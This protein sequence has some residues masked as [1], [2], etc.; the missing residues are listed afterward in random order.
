[1]KDAVHNPTPLQTG[2]TLGI[3]APAGG[4]RDAAAFQTGISI[5]Q[6]MGF[7]VK[8]PK[9]CWENEISGYLAGDAAERADE[10][11]R[12][13]ADSEVKGIIALRGGF[14]CLQI[15]DRLDFNLI[16]E[17]P[18]ILIGFSDLTIILNTIF[19]QTKLP[20]FH[21]PTVTTLA[22]AAP[23]AL[24][25]FYKCLTTNIF[26]YPALHFPFLEI[27]HNGLT[28]TAEI[29]GGNLTTLTTLLGT[30]WDFSYS[31][32]ILLLEDVGEPI[33][34]IDRM[35]T[36]LRLAGKFNQLAAI[37][38]G[39]FHTAAKQPKLDPLSHLRYLESI[40]QLVIGHCRKVNNPCPVWANISAGHS[41][42]NFTI[43][44]GAPTTMD[45]IK[46]TISFQ[47][48]PIK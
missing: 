36:Q 46:K 43:P 9:G 13:W 31:S 22:Q 7:S 32:K 30:P 35:L 12:M 38:L 37:L 20:T 5:L 33:Y 47:K 18:K 42:N 19:I 39:D 8:F 24:Q 2:D 23:P 15:L 21:G 44:I 48:Q 25:W 34:K 14:G 26:H 10:F 11:N 4:L 3:V 28:V 17:N 27:L 40:W 45:T 41:A 1:M 6:E 16:Q 29:I